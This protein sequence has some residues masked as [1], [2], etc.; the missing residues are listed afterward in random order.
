MLASY[1]DKT[2]MHKIIESYDHHQR[3]ISQ[4]SEFRLRTNQLYEET[5]IIHSE[6][7]FHSAFYLADLVKDLNLRLVTKINYEGSSM[8]ELTESYNKILSY[9]SLLPKLNIVF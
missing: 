6:F 3:Q 9:L 7:N 1:Q 5:Q 2:P 8:A 4:N